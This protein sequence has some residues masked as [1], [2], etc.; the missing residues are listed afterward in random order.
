MS[1]PGGIGRQKRRQ[2]LRRQ[3]HRS[4]IEQHTSWLAQAQAHS[5]RIELLSMQTQCT[6][7]A[8]RCAITTKRQARPSALATL[9]AN[10]CS[11]AVMR[12]A[13]L[14]EKPTQPRHLSWLRD[15][16]LLR[17]HRGRG[18]GQHSFAL[19]AV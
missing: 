19:P 18:C 15:S 5:Q 9:P 6:L 7:A 14:T 1:Q 11:P 17:R 4:V 8:M 13:I 10:R 3:G 2:R 12:C 16:M